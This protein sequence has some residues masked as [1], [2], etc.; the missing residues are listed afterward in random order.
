[1]SRDYKGYKGFCNLSTSESH[2][3][4]GSATAF[5]ERCFPGLCHT[6]KLL[7]TPCAAQVELRVL[8]LENPLCG[9]Q[10]CSQLWGCRHG[11]CELPL[12][13]G[14]LSC[15]IQQE[16]SP[17]VS[18]SGLTSDSSTTEMDRGTCVSF[19]HQYLPFTPQCGRHRLINRHGDPRHGGSRGRPCPTRLR[20]PCILTHFLQADTSPACNRLWSP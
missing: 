17:V 18:A 6:L 14:S 13:V 19:H 12:T 11:G 1:M 3:G 16:N 4:R 20:Q 2:Q 8:I 15:L 10:Q 7:R 9:Q 5:S